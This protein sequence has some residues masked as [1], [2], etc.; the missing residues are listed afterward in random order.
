MEGRIGKLTSLLIICCFL[1][2][3]MIITSGCGGD[4]EGIN[5]G[6]T[7]NI[8]GKKSYL[9][10]EM[11]IYFDKND[12]KELENLAAFLSNDLGN[13]TPWHI[14][15]FHPTYKLTDRSHTPVATLLAAREIGIKA[16]LKYVYLGNVPG[17]GGEK[18]FCYQCKNILID[19]LGFHVGEN[20]IKNSQCTHCGARIQGVGL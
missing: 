20:Q 12:K 10:T 8:K 4:K 17:Q 19:R 5:L 3:F 2:G 18:T 11:V 14:S 6:F 1:S 16:G 15:R 9:N 7:V 13:E